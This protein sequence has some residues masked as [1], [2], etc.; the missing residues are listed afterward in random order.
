LI[1]PAATF[2]TTATTVFRD[3]SLHRRKSVSVDCQGQKEKHV[4]WCILLQ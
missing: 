4:S 2:T 1:Q 3:P